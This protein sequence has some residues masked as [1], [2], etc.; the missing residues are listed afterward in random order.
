MGAGK[1]TVGRV[2]SEK[3]NTPFFDLDEI[4]E[5]KTGEKIDEIF[6][7]H[8]ETY[9]RKLESEVLRDTVRN[10]NN[11]VISTG[12]GIVLDSSNRE[13]IAKN[14]ISVYL[15]A[16]INTLWPRIAG[17]NSRPLLK[18]DNPRSHADHLLAER[19]GLY[20]ESEFTVITDNLTPGEVAS[21]IIAYLAELEQ[22]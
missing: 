7:K 1:T 20:E 21:E 2:L 15:K 10:N 6:K 11:F 19:S 9:F 22:I 18:V 13:F 4:I 3:I 8:G 5:K 17:N 16:D 12:G 14:G